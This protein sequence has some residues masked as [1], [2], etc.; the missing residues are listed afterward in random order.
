M[1]YLIEPLFYRGYYSL[2]HIL[3]RAL[4]SG[5]NCRLQCT[6]M[7][8][9]CCVLLVYTA[10]I[11]LALALTISNQPTDSLSSALSV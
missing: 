4:E 1:Q 5:V 2:L 3:A 6:A 9:M 7:K 10:F 8:C 11:A